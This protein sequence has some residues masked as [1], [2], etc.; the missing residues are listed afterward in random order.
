MTEEQ[1]EEIYDHYASFGKYNDDPP[2]NLII[3]ATYTLGILNVEKRS[4]SFESR[5][6]KI[7]FYKQ[8][9]YLKSNIYLS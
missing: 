9:I 2:F 4:C 7:E 6:N 5:I 1:A 3:I 8:I